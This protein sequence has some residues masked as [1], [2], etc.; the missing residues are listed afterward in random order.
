MLHIWNSY[1]EGNFHTIPSSSRE[2]SVEYQKQQDWSFTTRNGKDLIQFA[3][4]PINLAGNLHW[5]EGAL[6]TE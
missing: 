4:T 3:K 2:T 5:S 1:W 6:K